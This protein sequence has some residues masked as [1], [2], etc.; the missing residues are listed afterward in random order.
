M[1]LER[2]DQ[3]QFFYLGNFSA[4]AIFLKVLPYL[5]LRGY[6]IAVKFQCNQLSSFKGICVFFQRLKFLKIVSCLPLGVSTFSTIHP[7]VFKVFKELDSQVRCASYRCPAC[8]V[9]YAEGYL[10]QYTPSVDIIRLIIVPWLVVS[11]AKIL[12]QAI[13]S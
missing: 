8:S 13:Y 6:Y 12:S 5:P 1:E 2:K 7:L 11:P 10:N 9:Q 3:Q 4:W